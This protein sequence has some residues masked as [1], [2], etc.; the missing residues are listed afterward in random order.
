MTSPPK[1]ELVIQEFN[2]PEE[3]KAGL[4]QLTDRCNALPPSKQAFLAQV[5]QINDPEAEV[6]AL[7]VLMLEN[8]DDQFNITS[9]EVNDLIAEALGSQETP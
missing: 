5:I 2:T 4:A 1:E 8:S 6:I 3:I 7:L 9:P